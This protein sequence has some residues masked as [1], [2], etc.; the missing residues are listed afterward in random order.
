MSFKLLAIRPLD[1]CNPKFLKNLEESRIY[2]F[3][4]DY[5]FIQDN[6][7]NI[8]SLEYKETVPEELYYQEEGDF[9]TKV[10][11]CAIV[12]KNGS[13]KSALVELLVASVV[14]LSLEIK[15]DFVEAENL[16]YDSNENRQNDLITKFNNSKIQDLKDINVEMFIIHKA[17]P[18][19]IHNEE[20]K[21]FGT[22]A[23]EKIR[24]IRLEDNKITITD[25]QKSSNIF[26]KENFDISKEVL[27]SG[28]EIEHLK[29]SREE[30]HFFQDFFYTMVINYSHYGYNAL[31][32]GE[33]L[34]GVFHKN[35]GYQL[36]VVINP[37]R[38][39]GNININSEKELSKSRFLV[40]ILQEP[41][42]RTISQGKTV[43]HVSIE[44]NENK[45]IG[46]NQTVSAEW[47]DWDKEENRN[48]W[49]NIS[50]E[51][52]QEILNS[53]FSIFYE[54]ETIAIRTNH[55]LYPF[56]RDYIIFKLIRMRH[57]SVYKEFYDCFESNDIEVP[58]Y[59]FPITRSKY[60][61][62]NKKKLKYYFKAINQDISHN[63]DKLRQ[64]LFFLKYL[65]LDKNDLF[66]KD[67]NEK[68]LEITELYEKIHHSWKQS[69]IDLPAISHFSNDE[70]SIR[71]S[72]PSIFKVNYYFNEVPSNNHFDNFS[73]GEKQKL[74]SI[75][76][77]IYHLR[78]LKS[79]QNHDQEDE[80]GEEK[81]KELINYKNVNIIFDEIELYAHP[82]FQR[83]FIHDFL[84]SLEAVYK[85]SSTHNLNI[86]F[87]TH[88]P[89]ILSD[90]PRQ[91][92][93]FLEVDEETKKSVP[94]VYKGDNTFAENIH[95]MLT[96]GFFITSTKGEFAISKI[97]EFL[98]DYNEYLYSEEKSFE[99]LK[100]K[101]IKS[102]RD[103]T[104]LIKMIGEE[105]IRKILESQ[106]EEL[107]LYFQA[108]P[109]K[110]DLKNQE[111]LLIEQLNLIRKQL[112]DEEN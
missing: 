22:N 88:S 83:K 74:Y 104:L 93:L 16:Y 13:G 79:V 20:L 92:V 1:G 15:K 46:F 8:N 97:N 78:N 99:E 82:E 89:F 108:P 27:K 34:K 30:L 51:E 67:S 7:G 3:Y 38:E 101:F 28:Q 56:V 59:D 77:V 102:K 36:P 4:N 18:C 43:T 57:Y 75:H 107:N 17:E 69:R 21:C 70:F 94:K 50:E 29:I 98:N 6:E 26:I 39:E 111:I 42:L 5:K 73:S 24:K 100:N 110:D 52:K 60:S 87:I 54:K 23:K 76:S 31:E 49:L 95:E 14:K 35:D 58:Y 109:S 11:I 91:N 64:A 12:G 68:L 47:H 32:S 25:F 96:D 2:Q 106:L 112:R 66:E 81:R 44:L 85:I 65:Y 45:F 103:Y 55:F 9:K 86:I 53:L 84:K 19:I 37:M 62:K 10:N 80:H 40:N 90:I 41:S 71:E 72:L 105:Y 61:I 33:W 48:Q 63:T